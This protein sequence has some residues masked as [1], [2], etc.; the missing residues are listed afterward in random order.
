MRQFIRQVNQIHLRWT[1]G[2]INKLLTNE[3][4]TPIPTYLLLSAPCKGD[5][6]NERF[7]V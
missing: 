4:D 5:N 1:K 2:G 3:S 7:T 6:W